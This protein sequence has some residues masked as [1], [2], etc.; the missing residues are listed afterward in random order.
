MFSIIVLLLLCLGLQV[1]LNAAEEVFPAQELA[2][3]VGASHGPWDDEKVVLN[4]NFGMRWRVQGDQLIL[5]L[6]SW[7]TVGGWM[8]FGF[9]EPSSG[10]MLGADLVL[11]SLSDGAVKVSDTHVPFSAYPLTQAPLPF[12]EAD[13]IQ[14]WSALG[15]KQTDDGMV[16]VLQRKLD[17]GDNQD[18]AVSLEKGTRVL[19][20]YGFGNSPAYH[21]GNRGVAK[22]N[23]GKVKQV[24]IPSDADSFFD[25]VAPDVVLPDG[26]S[27]SYLQYAMDLGDNFPDIVGADFNVVSPS[28]HFVHHIILYDCGTSD[29]KDWL[30]NFGKVEVVEASVPISTCVPMFGWALGGDDTLVVPRDA[31]L[32][33]IRY[34]VLEAHFNQPVMGYNKATGEPDHAGAGTTDASGFRLYTTSKPRRLRAGSMLIKGMG[35][36]GNQIPA[37]AG[38]V[39][40]ESICSGECTKRNPQPL[41]VYNSFLHMHNHGRQI[42]ASHYDQDLNFEGY[43]GKTEFW[44]ANFQNYVPENVTIYPGDT[45]GVHCV[46]DTNKQQVGP[47]WG[48]R[49]EDEMCLVILQFYSE[50]EAPV[51]LCGGMTQPAWTGIEHPVAVCNADVLFDG[52][53]ALDPSLEVPCDVTEYGT[54]P[55][56]NE[57]N[58][59]LFSDREA[60]ECASHHPSMGHSVALVS[61]VAIVSLALLLVTYTDIFRN[62]WAKRTASGRTESMIDDSSQA[63]TPDSEHFERKTDGNLPSQNESL[64]DGVPALEEPGDAL[65]HRAKE[66]V[67]EKHNVPESESVLER[68]HQNVKSDPDKLL[69]AWLDDKTNV[70]NKLT[71]QQLWDKSRDLAFHLQNNC[72]VKPGDRVMIVYPFGIEFMVGFVALLRMGAVIVSVFPPNPKNLTGDIPKFAHFV[73]DCG[74]TVALTTTDYH[75]LVQTSRLVYKTWPQGI[76][77][78][79]SDAQR[80]LAPESYMDYIPNPENTA[81]IQYT[82]G[83]TSSPKGVMISYA[84]M[85]HQVSFLQNCY[86]VYAGTSRE[87]TDEIVNVSWT[88]QFH[89]MGLFGSFIVYLSLGGTSYSMSPI[90]FL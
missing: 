32:K 69:Y 64:E 42:W 28:P 66:F 59:Q 60:F 41:H 56:T 85:N 16:V 29:K 12:P 55:L 14:D 80:P 79:K 10:S 7:S 2:D 46:F 37:G 24:Q 34:V 43:I 6:A 27:D 70:V 18:R 47:L 82:S 30:R 19:F 17:T 71:R 67:K 81:L 62:I 75:R 45:I 38:A 77:W 40:Y 76:T 57:Y 33:G 21:G 20:A 63:K 5:L 1:R 90:S 25:V 72:G 50:E 86:H 83:S 35:Q 13:D 65:L 74:A 15:G 9:G 22:I 54:F 8:G 3:H 36:T 53:S 44:N 87:S 26:V 51:K 52:T 89:D 61:A 31:A 11:A 23:F 4:G 48:D 88:P 84:N 49:T 68:F 39:H 58:P 78:V 73:E